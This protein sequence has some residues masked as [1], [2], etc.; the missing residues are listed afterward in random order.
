MDI[1]ARPIGTE[2][3]QCKTCAH[4]NER[5]W[6]VPLAEIVSAAGSHAKLKEL[7][8]EPTK[9]EVTR[10]I[11]RDGVLVAINS[12]DRAV[13]ARDIDEN[14]DDIDP[15][16]VNSCGFQLA[17][18]CRNCAR[19]R[20]VEVIIPDPN[21]ER[22]NSTRKV[23]ISA[24][25]SI[26]AEGIVIEGRRVTCAPKPTNRLANIT[27]SCENCRFS[28]TTDER[29][30]LDDF[31]VNDADLTP[32][33]ME[34]ARLSVGGDPEQVG[35][36]INMARRAKAQVTRGRVRWYPTT[37][38]GH[39][40]DPEGQHD[41]YKV[42][43]ANGTQAVLHYD[44]V[45]VVRYTV[46]RQTMENVQVVVPPEAVR[47]HVIKGT[48][49]ALEIKL[50][51][52]AP[53]GLIDS[54][55]G[56]DGT[57]KRT[58][59]LPALP[60]RIGATYVTTEIVSRG[61]IKRKVRK[62][63]WD[64]GEDY[65]ASKHPVFNETTGLVELHVKRRDP[66]EVDLSETGLWRL[67]VI[68]DDKGWRVVDDRYFWNVLLRLWCGQSVARPEEGPHVTVFKLRLRS[69]LE[70]AERKGGKEARA[71]V[72][73]QFLAME[74]SYPLSRPYLTTPGIF[75]D[76]G[77]EPYKEYCSLNLA[78][79][80]QGINFRELFGDSF[81]MDRTAYSR[82]WSYEMERDQW[83]RATHAGNEVHGEIMRNE[84][85][86][87]AWPEM[88][89]RSMPQ[90]DKPRLIMLDPF[91]NEVEDWEELDEERMKALR[92]EDTKAY[93][94]WLDELVPRESEDGHVFYQDRKMQVHGYTMYRGS[95]LEAAPNFVMDESGDTVRDQLYCKEC[96][97]AH[98]MTEMVSD[99]LPVLECPDCGAEMYVGRPGG[100][101]A[102]WVR[103]GKRVGIGTAVAADSESYQNRQRLRTTVCPG[104]KFKYNPNIT[105]NMVTPQKEY[106]EPLK[107]KLDKAVEDILEFEF[108]GLD[109]SF[110]GGD[111]SGGW[112]ERYSEE[113]WEKLQAD[114]ARARRNLEGTPVKIRQ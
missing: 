63:V 48:K 40:E 57:T 73:S 44:G 21:P 98:P 60:D 79:P 80:D 45:D 87:P 14:S 53:L 13:L 38:L 67:H 88:S 58:R 39:Y 22:K 35:R 103:M 26:P 16:Y 25:C 108:L 51:W 3:E 85:M 95:R 102:T 81:G 93:L 15:A 61:G 8:C 75:R 97:K 24:A 55:D 42:Q 50:P 11:R 109:A 66:N 70:I 99:Y 10:K 89:P 111:T 56:N 33:E 2:A 110:V 105:F 114:R 43:M 91:G 106:V 71:A 19:L 49:A 78:D 18:K 77:L 62:R 107:P 74:S 32:Y 4:G 86:D 72:Q 69:L 12:K 23:V 47:L 5:H 1:V 41:Q 104:W 29:W 82:T 90:L 94:E 27:P 20:K 31:V 76:T 9:V 7:R 112:I 36:A 30:Q 54:K 68:N 113:G 92:L 65:F 46:V 96:D 37:I 101:P 59:N 83:Y 100:E 28:F 64:R 52:Q 84:L 17:S 6:N 34:M